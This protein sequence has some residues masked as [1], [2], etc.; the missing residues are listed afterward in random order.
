MAQVGGGAVV[1][2]AGILSGRCNSVRRDGRHTRLCSAYTEMRRREPHRSVPVLP[3]RHLCSGSAFIARPPRPLPTGVDANVLGPASSYAGVAHTAW[4]AAGLSEVY[5]GE[6]LLTVRLLTQVR[7]ANI[8]AHKCPLNTCGLR[9]DGCGCVNTHPFSLTHT[10][11]SDARDP[12]TDPIPTGE[13]D[14]W[15]HGAVVR[16]SAVLTAA[17][18][19]VPAA[20]LIRVDVQPGDAMADAPVCDF[21]YLLVLRCDVLLFAIN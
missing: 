19:A 21:D 13:E 9:H 17:I 4:S 5:G 7:H 11:R 12:R 15:V 8:C 18:Q 6:G 14:R 3:I 10:G 2:V 16:H 1:A 20:A